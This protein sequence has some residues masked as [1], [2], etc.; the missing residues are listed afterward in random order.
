MKTPRWFFGSLIAL[1][2]VFGW[3]AY[4]AYST[5]KKLEAIKDVKTEYMMI[6]GK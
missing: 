4:G 5:M 2:L 6:A 3:N 1:S